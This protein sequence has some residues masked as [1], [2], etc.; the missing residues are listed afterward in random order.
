MQSQLDPD[1][2][3]RVAQYERNRQSGL[4]FQAEGTLGGQVAKPQ[5]PKRRRRWVASLICA[6]L[7]FVLIKASVLHIVGISSYNSSL[8]RLTASRS[9][10]DR[11]AGFVLQPDAATIQIAQ[12]LNNAQR[13]II[14]EMRLL[15]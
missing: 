10:I 9:V 2:A 11:A 14:R 7:M 12:V 6:A 13:R 15:K 5:R 8:A 4:V 1:F 3:A